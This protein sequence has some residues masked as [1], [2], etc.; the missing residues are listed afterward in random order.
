M[1]Y[2]V[3]RAMLRDVH[4]AEDAS[5]QSFLSA[6]RALLGGA[7]VRD[8]GA[9]LAT[10]AR[11]EC[12]GRI[13]AG[14]RTPLPVAEEDL[15]GIAACGDETERRLQA[16]ALRAA[17]GELPDRQRDA[18]VLRYLYGLRYSEVATALGISRPATEALLFRAR[19]AMRH[20]LRPVAG[21]VLAVP[22]AVRDELAL[23][24][25]G[26]STGPGTGAAAFGVTGGLLAKLTAG[27]VGAK[28]ATAVVAVSAVGVVGAVE[29]DPSGQIDGRGPRP[30][31][32]VERSVHD[33][34]RS[35][36]SPR[37]DGERSRSLDGRERDSGG[38]A[39]R[40]SGRIDMAGKGERRLSGRDDESRQD[41]GAPGEA[42]R[43][44]AGRD[45]DSASESFSDGPGSAAT[46]AD[47]SS[48]SGSSGEAKDDELV[49]SIDSDSG[50]SGSD[51]SSG[52]GGG[53]D[54]A[55]SGS[56]SGPGGGDPDD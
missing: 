24:I 8:S 6:Y 26:F 35:D 21:A 39:D 47:D 28:V 36:S 23:A 7:R 5:Q 2:G 19:R 16:E 31:A 32:V 37:S 49:A 13:A 44:D 51:D 22:L 33:A 56:N 50:D 38:D 52:P 29:S 17:L 11:N 25:P 18:V 34:G 15:A 54:D 10:I 45:D 9:W 3:C 30:A 27:S 12:R 46:V 20:S 1:V 48:T 42:S 41:K 40:A 53:S 4:E 14:M 55:S 43:A